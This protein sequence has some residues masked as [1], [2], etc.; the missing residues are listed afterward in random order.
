MVCEIGAVHSALISGTNIWAF[1]VPAQAYPVTSPD[2]FSH[3][4]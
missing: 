3:F 4:T 2:R 1:K